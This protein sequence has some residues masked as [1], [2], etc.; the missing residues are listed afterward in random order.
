ME[1]D[2]QPMRHKT[3]INLLLI[4][5]IFAVFWP[6]YDFGFI[7]LDDPGYVVQNRHVHKGLSLASVH[8]AFTTSHMGFWIPL[9]WL[10]F[11]LD[12]ELYGLNA[13]GYHL[14]NLILHIANTLLLFLLLHR[15]TQ[16]TWQSAFVAALFAVHP[17]RVEFMILSCLL[18]ACGNTPR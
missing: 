8:W 2:L 14:T 6:M 11:M 3:L 18:S 1:S 4:L 12:F 13:A 16:K 9:T 17:L 5:T 7:C 10:S 15:M